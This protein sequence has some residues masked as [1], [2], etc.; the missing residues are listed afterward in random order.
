MK[1]NGKGAL[2]AQSVG[3][4]PDSQKR[5]VWSIISV[6]IAALTV[7]AVISQ[8]KNFSLGEFLEQLKGASPWWIAAAVASM[9]AYICFEAAALLTICREFGHAPTF[10]HGLVYSSADLYF[11]AITPSATGGQPA[12]AFFMRLDGMSDKVS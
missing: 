5:I 7:W 2:P 8:T 6:A 9:I 3:K 4:L 1:D 11:S 10:R 12:S